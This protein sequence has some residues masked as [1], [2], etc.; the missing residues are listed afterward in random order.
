MA[1]VG[2][3]GPLGRS[4]HRPVKTCTECKQ[5]K[6]HS[7]ETI[8]F[9]QDLMRNSFVATVNRNFQRH[10]PGVR[11]G[12]CNVWLIH[13]SGGRQPASTLNGFAIVDIMCLQ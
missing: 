10:A 9:D 1:A 3:L 4:V 6:V 7:F 5:V 12:I 11:L 13:L 8:P 2:A